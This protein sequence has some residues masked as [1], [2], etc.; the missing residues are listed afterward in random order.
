MTFVSSSSSL[1]LF[2]LM[3][4][5]YKSSL[6]PPS[7]FSSSPS[8]FRRYFTF[9]VKRVIIF[10]TFLFIFSMILPLFL[11]DSLPSH[12]QT[13]SQVNFAV[14]S[15]LPSTEQVN[16]AI[17]APL[18]EQQQPQVIPPE[19]SPDPAAVPT[20][21]VNEI[22]AGA[23]QP[24][25]SQQ[26]VQ[27]APV[28]PIPDPAQVVN[29]QQ[30]ITNKPLPAPA[31][32][33]SPLPSPSPPVSPSSSVSSLWSTRASSVRS[34]FAYAWSSYF[35]HCFGQDEFLPVSN[36]CHD[37]IHAGLTLIDSIP[38][39]IIMGGFDQELK[40]A[41]DW[42]A[43]SLHFDS[44]SIFT[45][46]FET[47]IRILGGL[48]SIYDFTQD[49]IYLNLA[50]DLGDRLS[51]CFNTPT[52]LP[53]GQV[54]LATKQCTEIAWSGGAS[55]LSEIGTC[56]VEFFYLSHW[57][58]DSKYESLAQRVIDHLD[59]L[60]KPYPGLYPVY[61]SPATGQFT[62]QKIMFGA[63]GDSFYEYLL[64]VWLLTGRKNEQYRRM[65]VECMRGMINSLYSENQDGDAWIAEMD[66]GRKIE[67][68]DHLA[69]FIP[70]M[71]ALGAKTGAVEGEEATKHLRIAD[72][73][74]ETCVKSYRFTSSGIGPEYF[75]FQPH[76][77]VGDA[78]YNMR[79]EVVESLFV[80]WRVTG[81][82]KWRRYGWEI[83]ESIERHCRLP[84]GRG[85]TGLRNVN[86][87]NDK[88]DKMESFFLAETLKYLYL[89][90]GENSK[91][92]IFPTPENDEYYVFN[93]ECHP[94]KAWK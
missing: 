57:T 20:P 9:S 59:K 61:I 24:I 47:T 14:K 2:L 5:S 49:E 17:I 80:L 76:M 81:D 15:D 26:N 73:L 22:P 7:G 36:R 52:G 13:V 29:P 16:Q 89:L 94:V 6:P 33:P 30:T 56:Q 74:L 62:N 48:N 84:D 86:Q 60:P 55:L 92:P 87:P 83:F 82:E 27:S 78:S 85:Y 18:G 79:P 75:V 38:T 34:S 53:K 64:K 58:K 21:Q 28:T 70:G 4:S 66:Y 45:S 72:R 39:A 63:L 91:I 37:W 67:K 12:E 31:P 71:L 90:F 54:N 19:P 43:S 69:C 42:I 8:G 51:V 3:F 1:I 35:D 44:S 88:L 32:L 25:Q 77:A 46:F 10:V 23:A 41:R 93:T 11:L 65:Y 40:R 68:Q 50:K